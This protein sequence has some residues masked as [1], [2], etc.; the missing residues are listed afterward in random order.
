MQI[1]KLAQSRGKQF[2]QHV[3]LHLAYRTTLNAAPDC[4]KR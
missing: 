1:C 2:T 3:T 4:L